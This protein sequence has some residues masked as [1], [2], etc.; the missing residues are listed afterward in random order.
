MEY[1]SRKS[2][3][4]FYTQ[5]LL[6]THLHNTITLSH[7]Y[8]I[9]S[10]L[11]VLWKDHFH[12]HTLLVWFTVPHNITFLEA[13]VWKIAQLDFLHSIDKMKHWKLSPGHLLR[14][15][16]CRK[17]FLVWTMPVHSQHFLKEGFFVIFNS[18]RIDSC[19]NWPFFYN[20]LKN[21]FF[22]HLN[23]NICTLFSVCLL[24]FGMYRGRYW[25]HRP[26]HCVNKC[27]L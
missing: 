14:L 4:L 1:W 3:M 9:F 25:V 8:I 17:L 2:H 15:Y 20:T 6:S 12:A 23:I 5:N 27:N 11:N 19:C 18:L 7:S 13:T 24:F 10:L 16:E 26:N 21:I 22:V